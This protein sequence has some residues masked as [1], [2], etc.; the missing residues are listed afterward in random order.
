MQQ[1]LTVIHLFIVQF[2]T[3]KVNYY[4]VIQQLCLKA[5]SID[6]TM[7]L[8]VFFFSVSVYKFKQS[9][10]VWPL[11]FLY[12]CHFGQTPSF[13]KYLAM[14]L[15]LL[16]SFTLSYT[17]LTLSYRSFT[18]SYTSFTLS[19][20]SFTGNGRCISQYCPCRKLSDVSHSIVHAGSC[21]MYLTV[22]S[23]QEAVR[24]ISQYCPCRKLSDVTHSIVH[25]GS[26][27]M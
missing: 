26:C 2:S 22:L 25:A 23:M 9:F 24:C 16:N 15:S 11:L 18:L 14:K 10:K 4:I 21:Q 20:T 1:I 12:H 7:D 8:L 6:W 17:S 5:N 3:Y 13:L 19:Y 27:Q